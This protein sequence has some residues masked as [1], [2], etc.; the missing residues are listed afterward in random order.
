MK[1]IGHIG[2]CVHSVDTVI[3]LLE[4]TVGVTRVEYVEMPERGQRSALVTLGQRG[5]LLELME[6]MG[7]G[8]TVA[9]FLARHGEGLHHI[10]LSVGSVKETAAAFEAAGCLIIE[11]KQGIGFVHPKSAFGVLWEIVDETY[12]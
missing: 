5:D 6:P 12:Q 11:K 10:S 1:K 7:E 4:K 2:I 9:D 8:G 3:G